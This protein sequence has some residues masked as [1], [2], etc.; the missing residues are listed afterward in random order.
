MRKSQ[1]LAEKSRLEQDREDPSAQEQNQFTEGNH[2]REQLVSEQRKNTSV[3]QIN[4]GTNRS[5]EQGRDTTPKHENSPQVTKTQTAFYSDPVI[6]P[7]P[8]PPDRLAQNDRHIN[9]DL[10][11]EIKHWRK[12]TISRR[13]NIRNISKTR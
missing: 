4:Q 1:K 5:I 8:R 7:P 3:P 6:K 9:L 11:L 12:F 10:D 2:V 13:S